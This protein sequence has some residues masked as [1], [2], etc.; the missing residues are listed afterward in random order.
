MHDTVTDKSSTNG[1]H[2]VAE[3]GTNSPHDLLPH[4]D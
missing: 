2:L 1:D 4:S 3:I